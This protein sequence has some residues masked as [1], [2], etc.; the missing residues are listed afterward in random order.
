[1]STSLKNQRI[2]ILDIDHTIVHSVSIKDKMFVSTHPIGGFIIEGAKFRYMVF[3]RPGL[4][5]FLDFCFTHFDHVIFWSAGTR[6]YVH[7]ILANILMANHVPLLVLTREDS[8][9]KDGNTKKDMAT[10]DRLLAHLRISYPSSTVIFVDDITK[11]IINM[12]DELDHHVIKADPFNTLW[13]DKLV[14]PYWFRIILSQ[15]EMVDRDSYLD[16]L[17]SDL[18]Q[19]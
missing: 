15:S 17:V 18:I 13:K 8:T 10:L 4:D 3:K 16:E 14:S 6:D 12:K 7:C 19:Y 9:D 1:M 2:L 5:T 11:R